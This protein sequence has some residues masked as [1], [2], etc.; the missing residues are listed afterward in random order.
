LEYV[1]VDNGSSDDVVDFI[2]DLRYARTSIFNGENRGI[3]HAMNQARRAAA[4]EYF[5]NLE[6]DWLF[7]YRS[8]WMERGVLLFEADAKGEYVDKRPRD[9]PLG[10]VKYKLGAGIPN[11]TNNPSL[12]SRKAYEIAGEFPQYGREYKYVSEDVHRIEK[13]YIPRFAKKF[14]C[15]LSET[16]CALHIGGFT[17]NPNYGNKKRRGFDELDGLLESR[18]KEGRMLAA[19]AIMKARNRIRLKKALKHY[20]EFERDRDDGGRMTMEHNLFNVVIVTY[21]NGEMLSQCIESVYESRG[22]D[23]V[24]CVVTVVDN[25]SSDGTREIVIKRFPR[26]KYIENEENLGLAKA[27]NIGVRSQPGSRYTLIMN[28]DTKLFPDAIEK[29][30]R[31]LDAHR[32]AMGVPANLLRPDGSLQRMK[33]RIWG[34]NRGRRPRP[35]YVSFSGT[36]ACLYRTEALFALGLFD[37]FFFFYNEDLDFAIRAKRSGARFFFDPEAKVIHVKSQGRKKGERSVKPHF[38]A[39]NYY[40]Y[41]KLFGGLFAFLYRCAA[42]VHIRVARKRFSRAGE[43]EK[44]RMLKEGEERLRRARNGFMKKNRRCRSGA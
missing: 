44:L 19:Y 32:D 6:N 16:P 12:M 17:T 38:F 20:R 40:L 15:A 7:F 27:I 41:R 34:I 5:F 30:L 18:W 43:T 3:G 9:L 23:N 31:A 8:D 26:V 1:F 42:D 10:L 35:R 39:T 24:R 21:K 37:E 13:D 36:T 11:F 29:M 25:N 4:G 28:D 14:A 22:L 33:L 2:K